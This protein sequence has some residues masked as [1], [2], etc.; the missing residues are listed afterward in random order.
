MRVTMMAKA[1]DGAIGANWGS[2]A[3]DI[4]SLQLLALGGVLFTTG[5]GAPRE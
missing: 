4:G 3:L 2:L 5:P 1:A